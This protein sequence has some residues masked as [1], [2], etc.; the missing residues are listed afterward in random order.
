MQIAQDEDHDK[1]KW[2]S[3]SSRFQKIL[4]VLMVRTS[5]GTF[6]VECSA[7]ACQGIKLKTVSSYAAGILLAA[8]CFNLSTH[9]S[10]HPLQLYWCFLS[11]SICIFSVCT[12]QPELALFS[13]CNIQTPIQSH[14]VSMRTCAV[15]MMVM[16]MWCVHNTVYLCFW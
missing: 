9:A 5:M 15:C 3:Y 1:C 11:N 6:G 4:Q 16:C 14:S 8:S 7:K 2:S 13:D 10:P 12:L